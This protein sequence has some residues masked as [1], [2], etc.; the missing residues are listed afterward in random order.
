MGGSEGPY[1]YPTEQDARNDVRKVNLWA[2]LLKE[3]KSNG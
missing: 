2:K 3:G 1:E